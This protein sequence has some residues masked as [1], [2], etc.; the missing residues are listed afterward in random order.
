MLVKEYNLIPK[1]HQGSIAPYVLRI[2]KF[3]ATESYFWSLMNNV[4]NVFVAQS[5]M[6]FQ[7]FDA[8]EKDFSDFLED[9]NNATF[10]IVQKKE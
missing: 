10:S 5:G 8:C 9:L 3:Q 7:T 4:K 6:K 1:N 2:V